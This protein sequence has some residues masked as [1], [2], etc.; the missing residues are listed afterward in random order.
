M[1]TNSDRDLEALVKRAITAS[2]VAVVV[3]GGTAAWHYVSPEQTTARVE[4]ARQTASR[5]SAKESAA[6]DAAR[7]LAERQAAGQDAQTDAQ[8]LARAEAQRLYPPSH[9]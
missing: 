1:N 7:A 2:L 6:P 5:Q 9:G 8:E 3:F 4:Q